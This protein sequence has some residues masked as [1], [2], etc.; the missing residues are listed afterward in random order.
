MDIKKVVFDLKISD[1]ETEANI[2]SRVGIA[3]ILDNGLNLLYAPQNFGKSYTSVA[4][5]KETGLPSI[6]FDL[7]SNGKI[8]VD[9]CSKNDVS[10]L[11]IG[12]SSN[13]LF[14][15]TQIVKELKV[16]YGKVFVIIDSYSDMFPDDEG[17][18]A[19]KAQQALGDLNKLFMRELEMPVLLLDHATEQLDGKFKIEG[20]KSGKFK[21]TLLVLRLEQ[22]GKDLNNGTFVKIE[23]SRSQDILPINHTQSYPR[24]NYLATK[25]KTLIDDKKLPSEFSY[26]D[27]ESKLSGNDRDLWRQSRDDIATSRK[28]DR[29]TFWT[30]K[31]GTS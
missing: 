27:L 15:M 16:R 26:K 21:K 24:G 31:E 19:Q 10:Y 2:N 13:P 7:E 1:V 17:K 4:I 6:F 9:F 30:L 20:N 18:M 11:Y 28:I 22:I 12:S 23:R 14:V 29:K 25:L 8:F 5:A 3:P